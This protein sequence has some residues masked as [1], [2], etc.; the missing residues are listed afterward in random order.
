MEKS[1]IIVTDK[2]RCGWPGNDSLYMDYH[3]NEWGYPVHDDVR[4]F[5]SLILDGFQAGLSWLTILRKRENFRL[6]F[7]GWDIPRI[8]AYTQQDF[9]RLLADS[10][11]VRNRLK[12]QA[13]IS[14][15]QAYLDIQA[16]FG[17]FD[18]YIWQFTEGQT[19]IADPRP[20]TLTDLPAK[21][22]MS[23]TISRDLKQRGFKFVGSTICYAFMQAVGIVDDHLE[24]CFRVNPDG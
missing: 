16:S 20:R 7:H 6:A 19:R 21:T 1:G 11:I 17:S 22:S 23:D 10:G 8:A 5:E 15:A 3:D 4:L 2:P 9:S 24:G 12:I 18:R 14:N 13:A